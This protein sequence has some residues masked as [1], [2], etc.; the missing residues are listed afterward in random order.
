MTDR[1]HFRLAAAQA[2]LAA[3]MASWEYAYAHAGGCHSGTGHPTHRATRERTA[4]LAARVAAAR[5]GA[6]GARHDPRDT[7]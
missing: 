7:P 2:E 4:L 6:G 5:A 1:N 3:H